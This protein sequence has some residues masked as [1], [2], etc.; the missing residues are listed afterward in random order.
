MQLSPPWWTFHGLVAAALGAD[1]EVKVS[2][3]TQ[4]GSTYSMQVTATNPAKAQALAAVL[5]QNQQFGNITV[6]VTVQGQHTSAETGL[7]PTQLAEQLNTAFKG[8]PYFIRTEVRPLWPGRPNAVVFPIF[9]A[10]VIQFFNDDLSDYYNNYNAVAA[11]VF[12]QMLQ[13]H[14]TMGPMCSTEKIG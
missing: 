12:G 5:V 6:Q 2:T 13:A 7:T 3:L 8:N 11:D 10:K 1:H 14:G 9:A 4:H